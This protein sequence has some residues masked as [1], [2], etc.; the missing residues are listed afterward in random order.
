[1]GDMIVAVVNEENPTGKVISET[2]LT[3]PDVKGR[4]ISSLASIIYSDKANWPGKRIN[5]AAAPYH[6]AMLDLETVN[7]TYG[8]DSGRSIVA[9]CL[10][11]ASTWR[12]P[13]AKAV[14]AELKSRI[15]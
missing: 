12:G 11:N 10:A 5:Y 6:D 9:Y 14:K 1:M 3:F 13:L 4:T 2:P 7:D 15:K 8:A